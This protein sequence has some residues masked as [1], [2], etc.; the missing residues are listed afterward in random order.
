MPSEFSRISLVTCPFGEFQVATCK[1]DSTSA[2][3]CIG[4]NSLEIVH[5]QGW[6]RKEV[7]GDEEV[8]TDVEAGRRGGS[9]ERTGY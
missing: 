5:W 6:D 2:S 7:E 4:R 1:V 8:Q 9:K 3:G